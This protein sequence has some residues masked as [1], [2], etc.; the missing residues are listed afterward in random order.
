LFHDLL[1]LS[2]HTAI[3]GFGTVLPRM[4]AFILLPV[5]THQFSPQ[6]FGVYQ[7]YYAAIALIMAFLP[8]GLDI[9]LLRF[10]VLEKDAGDRKKLFSSV[11]WAVLLYSIVLSG[12]L[13]FGSRFFL[14]LIVSSVTEYPPWMFYTL[15]LR[16]GVM[17]LD[18]LSNFPMWVMRGEGQAV[19]F[20]IIKVAGAIT[21]VVFTIVFL[22]MGRGVAAPF[23]GNL[24]ASVLMAVLCVPT[25]ISKLRPYVNW[26]TLSSCLAFGLPNVPNL[27]F[28]MLVEIS[29]RK[30]LELL[31]TPAEVGIYS[32]GYRLGMFLSIVALAFR[33]AWQPFFLQIADRPNAKQIYARVLTYYLAVAGWLF[34][35]LTAF[36][37]PLVKVNL[38]FIGVLIEQ[39]YW[40]GLGVFPII[41]L[42]HIC[43]GLWA[44]FMVGVYLQKRT[45]MLPLITGIAAAIN[46]FGNLALVPIWGMWA[47]AWLT[48]VAYAVMAGLLYFYIQRHYP[49]AYE[50]R[51]VVH[52]TVIGAGIFALG[53]IGRRHGLN[54][55]GYFLSLAFPL[56][57]LWTGLATE[58]EK[59]RLGLIK[60]KNG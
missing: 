25:I 29:D 1:K 21:Q 15:K 42:A 50:W 7:L 34:L 59:A 44:V 19:R 53:E 36:V 13:W 9:A 33:Y 38:P 14:H 48:F 54:W 35:L 40:A 43:N 60:G 57:L 45:G 16:I 3:Y 47:A 31:R 23:E 49:I 39:R 24:A 5:F 11:F 56:V 37:P 32:A 18:N 41:S 55:P 4:V 28:V 27:V 10:Y 20:S 17:F 58:T 51:R 26:S 46:I 22:E 2:R 12:L 6:E 8:L 52:L 30:I